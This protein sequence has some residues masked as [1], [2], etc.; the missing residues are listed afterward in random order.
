H[1][2]C[3]SDWSSDVCSSD[4]ER[5]ADLVAAID[6]APGATL[7]ADGDAALPALLAAAVSRVRAAIVDV[8]RF[9][10]SSDAAFLDRLYIPGIRR[11]IGRASCRERA[12]GSG[13]A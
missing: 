1:T 8:D 11:E 6:A 7:V 2:R 9:D 12:Y 4:L 13:G 3:L 5:V 10:R